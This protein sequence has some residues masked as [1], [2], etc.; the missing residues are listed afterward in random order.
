MV[1][2]L[3]LGLIFTLTTIMALAGVGAAFIVIPLLGEFGYEIS[4]AMALGLLFNTI[5]TGFSSI[6][7]IKEKKVEFYPALPIIVASILFT[8]V[9]SYFSS[10]V[11]REELKLLFG[12][13]LILI[14]LNIFRGILRMNKHHEKER[15]VEMSKREILLALGIGAI[16]GFLAGLL[17]I[18][19]GAI[20][21]PF[22]LKIGMETKR[23]AS[24]TSFIV[25]FSSFFGFY[26]KYLVLGL[27]IPIEILVG[28]IIATAL[29]AI[30]GSYLMHYKLNRKQIRMVIAFMVMSVGLKMVITYFL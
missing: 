16:I 17:G 26:S 19:G 10:L 3:L 22:L 11:P 25:V 20:I 6:R 27:S 28:G 1:E 24:T 2:I 5:S 29:G 18:G 15:A 4:L 8:P 12:I 30:L 21:L 13:A 14:S 23:A 9:G 7:H